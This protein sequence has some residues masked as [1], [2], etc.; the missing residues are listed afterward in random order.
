MNIVPIDKWPAELVHFISH[1]HPFV[2]SYYR[3]IS[4]IFDMSD[5]HQS[6]DTWYVWHSLASDI[7]YVWH[8]LAQWY[9]ICQ[10]VTSPVIFDMSDSHQSSDI[11][12]VW[13]SPVQDIWYVRYSQSRDTW[14]VCQPLA[15]LNLIC[16]PITSPMIFNMSD[17]YYSV[18]LDMPASTSQC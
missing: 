14:Y 15:Q 2:P 18:L 8:S 4:E 5:S 12:Y 9:L 1:R 6:S 7:W 10:T 13:H 11:W 17:S 16:L 3:D